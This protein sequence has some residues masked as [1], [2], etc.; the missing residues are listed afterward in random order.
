MSTSKIIGREGRLLW[1]SFPVSL[2][3]WMIEWVKPDTGEESWHGKAILSQK[4]LRAMM[5]ER[6]KSNLIP[7]NETIFGEFHKG[8]KPTVGS[9]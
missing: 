7:I 6:T 3:Y 4:D 2:K 1:D 9:S 8:K 5:E